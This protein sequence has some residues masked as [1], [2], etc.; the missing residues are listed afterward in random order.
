MSIRAEFGQ[1]FFCKRTTKKN[2]ENSTPST[3]WVRQWLTG[4]GAFLPDRFRSAY[5][6]S[7][8]C[9]LLKDTG[10]LSLF[11]HGS[12]GHWQWSMTHSIHD[13]LTYF[14]LCPACLSIPSARLV[15]HVVKGKTCSSVDTKSSSYIYSRTDSTLQLHKFIQ[16]CMH[17]LYKTAR[18]RSPVM[19]A[20][21]T[22][23]TWIKNK[24]TK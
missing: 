1:H 12:M 16:E 23:E 2:S 15:L 14:H 5:P 6:A 17:I 21:Y 7:D 22:W 19:T 10:H 20:V 11:H 3:L 24:Q 8:G 18:Q 13:P 9:A 4:G